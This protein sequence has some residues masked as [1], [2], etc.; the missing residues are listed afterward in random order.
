MNKT[1]IQSIPWLIAMSLLITLWF[2]RVPRVVEY[3][4]NETVA[5]FHQ[6]IGQS[7]LTEEQREQEINRFTQTLDDVVREYAVDNHVVV[8]VSPAVVSGAVNVTKEIQQSLLQTL[9]AQNI[10][11]R[12]QS[13]EGMAK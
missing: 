11:K 3:D 4:I 7:D 1:L 12:A 13:H 5:S 8:L 2:T 6:S 9:Q 10:A